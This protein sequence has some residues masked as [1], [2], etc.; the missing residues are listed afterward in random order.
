MLNRPAVTAEVA[1]AQSHFQAE[2]VA[3]VRKA[4][5]ENDVVV[6]GM[7][8]NPHVGRARKALD[9]AEVTYTYLG[10]GGYHSM[11]KER[12]AIKLWSGWPTFPQVYVKGR[13]IGGADATAAMLTDGTFANL[14]EADRP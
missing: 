12:L 9:A 5:A 2:I 6:V 1:S 8:L 7:A 10:Y 4:I 11:W 14:L 13:L 3:E